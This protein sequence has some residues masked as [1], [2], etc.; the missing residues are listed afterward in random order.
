MSGRQ[1]AF[2]GIRLIAVYLALNLLYYVAGIGETLLA[3]HSGGETEGVRG[4][5]FLYYGVISAIL[6]LG[7]SLTL[8]I[9]ADAIART[10]APETTVTGRQRP[11]SART[12]QAIAFS[13][14]GLFILVNALP[15]IAGELYRAHLVNSAL[16]VPQEVSF[17]TKARR[18][19]V[20]LEA[21]LGVAL[22]LGGGAPSGMLVRFRALGLPPEPPKSRPEGSTPK[23]R[24]RN[25]EG[26]KAPRAKK[27]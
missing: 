11:V 22:M 8:W 5:A 27:K 13:A 12:L 25:S 7:L 16:H 9:G 10:V 3:S 2:I 15:K 18:A 26:V 17:S 14:V 21:V 1:L 23:Q 19:Q 20:G 4:G 24:G 6:Y